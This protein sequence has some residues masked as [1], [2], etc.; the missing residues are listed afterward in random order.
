MPY[1]LLCACV[2]S[3][4][5]TE[6]DG[7]A[8]TRG[9]A[10]CVECGQCYEG[11]NC[12]T[13][14]EFK[15]R[16]MKVERHRRTNTDCIF[17]YQLRLSDFGEK[18]TPQPAPPNLVISTIPCLGLTQ[19][20]ADKLRKLGFQFARQLAVPS[21]SRLNQLPICGL[22]HLRTNPFRQFSI[23][24]RYV[25]FLRKS[26]LHTRLNHCTCDLDTDLSHIH[27]VWQ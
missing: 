7:E 3:G 14:F 24:G 11:R 15:T 6:R 13:G 18:G 16:E 12:C 19:S 22:P 1:H 9:T 26:F 25:L 27:Y 23:L 20:F 21:P 2:L 17:V 4:L 5:R 10:C 8:R